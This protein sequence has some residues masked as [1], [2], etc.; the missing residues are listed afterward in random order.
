MVVGVGYVDR[1]VVV[2]D[3]DGVLQPDVVISAVDISELEKTKSHD[4]SQPAVGRE[5]R[6]P[7]S[8]G[9]AY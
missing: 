2:S 8:A 5:I 1:S 3:S 6:R 7:D 4:G 9:F